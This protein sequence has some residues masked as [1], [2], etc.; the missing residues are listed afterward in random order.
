MPSLTRPERFLIHRFFSCG[1]SSLV[2]VAGRECST[3]PSF[4]KLAVVTKATMQAAAEARHFVFG[5]IPLGD[6]E[7]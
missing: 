5:L 1:P 3:W 7:S 2:W 6:T 4:R